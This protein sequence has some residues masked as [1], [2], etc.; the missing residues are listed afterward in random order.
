MWSG[1]LKWVGIQVK[2]KRLVG[3]TLF[4]LSCNTRAVTYFLSDSTIAG[5]IFPHAISICI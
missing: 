4:G 1:D 3:L 5:R 2:G